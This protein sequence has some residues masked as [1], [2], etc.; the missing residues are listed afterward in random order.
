MYS[1][2]KIARDA[3]ILNSDDLSIDQTVDAIILHLK[4]VH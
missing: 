3:I 4:D 1:P 2:L